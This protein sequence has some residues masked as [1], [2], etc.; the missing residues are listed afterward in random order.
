M[1]ALGASSNGS[2][3]VEIEPK[4]QGLSNDATME[5]VVQY[6][7]D[8]LHL[9]FSGVSNSVSRFTMIETSRSLENIL[10]ELSEDTINEAFK[11]KDVPIEYS[12]YFATKKG[13]NAVAAYSSATDSFIINK[14]YFGKGNHD[15]FASVIAKTT[16][17]PAS[18]FHPL[19]S[20]HADVLSHELGHLLEMYICR[21][22]SVQGFANYN[23]NSQ[24]FAKSIVDDAWNEVKVQFKYPDGKQMHKSDAMRS[25]SGYAATKGKRHETIAEAVA[26]YAA[27]G[28]KANPFSLAI[29]KR[30]KD[31]M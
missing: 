16:S 12:M 14:E 24:A 25:I 4:N 21:K 31:L 3:S 8:N 17:N 30:M 13:K 26:D 28:N 23:W 22:N 27:N 5:E 10:G 19:G 1:G 2:G 6:Y 20:S 7:K 18:H 11:G 15:K 29:W 9:D